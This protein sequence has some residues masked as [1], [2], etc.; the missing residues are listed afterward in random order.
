MALLAFL[1]PF[2]GSGVSHGFCYGRRPYG[3]LR[4][5]RLLVLY[6]VVGHRHRGREG[7]REGV[8]VCV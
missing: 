8:C 6:A 4:R 3:L 1:Q 2:P 5:C 7:E